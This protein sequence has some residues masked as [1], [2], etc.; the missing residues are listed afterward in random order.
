MS[1]REFGSTNGWT[2]G[3]YSLYRIALGAWFFLACAGQF[4]QGRVWAWIV[5]EIL[6]VPLVLGFKDRV[7]AAVLAAIFFYSNIAIDN[8]PAL[9]AVIW[10]LFAH[11]GV[12]PA[13]YGSLD[14]VGRPD[15]GNG[16]HVPQI[17]I[18][19]N[20]IGV[21]VI[22]LL[23]GMLRVYGW[24]VHLFS[25]QPS[26]AEI[27]T[28]GAVV[29]LLAS[30]IE[31]AFGVYAIAARIRPT[32]WIVM[33][34]VQVCVFVVLGHSLFDGGLVALHLLLFDPAWVAPSQPQT[35]DIVFYDGNC[36]LCHRAVRF[37]LAEDRLGS[38]FRFAP[39]GGEI[40]LASLT[41]TQRA[42]LPDSVAILTEDGRLLVR[43]AAVV[44]LLRRL[45]GIWKLVGSVTQ[46]IPSVLLDAAYDA[47]ARIRHRLFSRPK[48]ACPIIPKYLRTRF[49]N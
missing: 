2:G 25:T 15:P 21:S 44:H 8:T 36:G 42:S 29:L 18:R 28:P 38:A 3:Q 49:D 5:A 34:V 41:E 1:A 26:L 46:V 39:L 20:W 19:A 10:I 48:D 9:A 17:N 33:L 4:D 43:S 11:L 6:I 22:Y 7:F 14:A 13:P 31:I 40:F 27:A 24:Q 30:L 23:D 12:P 45:G 47:I 37:I 16:W 35:T 32:L